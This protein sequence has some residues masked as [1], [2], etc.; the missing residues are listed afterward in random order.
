MAEDEARHRQRTE[1]RLV[2]LSEA[3]LVSAFL[4]AGFIAGGGLYA[5][6]LGAELTGVAAVMGTVSALVSV[7]LF[8]QR[9][10][11]QAP[12]RQALAGTE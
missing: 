8:A 3:G 2:R 12:P 11:R 1:S 5:A 6:V 10:R 4:L 7:F 9:A